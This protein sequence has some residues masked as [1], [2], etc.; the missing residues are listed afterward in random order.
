M[1]YH[2]CSIMLLRY[3]HFAWV[4]SDYKQLSFLYRFFSYS[5][6]FFKNVMEHSFCQ[7]G[8]GVEQNVC[9]MTQEF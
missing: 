9:G 7:E 1:E 6:S 3:V 4:K 5:K 8:R 2:K